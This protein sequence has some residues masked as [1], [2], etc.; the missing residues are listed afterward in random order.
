M[1][2]HVAAEVVSHGHDATHIVIELRE[3]L[4]VQ[5]VLVEHILF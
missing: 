5:L 4:F 2:A 1:V 3:Q